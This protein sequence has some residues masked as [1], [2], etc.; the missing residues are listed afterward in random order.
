ML[1]LN[2]NIASLIGAVNLNR[3]TAEIEKVSQQISTG[4]RILTAADDPAGVGIVSTLRAQDMSYNAVVKNLTSGQS[5]LKTSE[6]ALKGQ[7]E[8]LT[9]MKDLATQ[10]SSGTLSAA[11]RTAISSQFTELQKQLD[12]IVNNANMFGQNLVGAAGANVTIQ[13]GI[14]A[15]QTTNVTA[16]KSDAA[17]LAVDA[18]AI[19]LNTA[20]GAQ[21]AMT[22]IDTAVGTV[23]SNQ[24]TIGTQLTGMNSMMTVAKEMQT[25][26]K[27]SISAI[28]D[29]DI[30]ALS[31]QLAQLQ[32][33]NQLMVQSLA[34]TNQMPQSL[35]QLLR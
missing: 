8:L 9:Q 7:Q 34:I 21:A 13:S 29:A 20:A 31:A 23:A 3:N 11:Q 17:T 5:L 32:T 22:A 15:G 24:A 2:T 25:Q 26:L 12:V 33:K 28:E 14:N 19:N 35:L 10:A 6:S 18:A 4:K 16:V 27:S 1:S 30:P